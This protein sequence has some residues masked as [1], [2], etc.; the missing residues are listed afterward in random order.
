MKKKT[1]LKNVI[2]LLG[3]ILISAGNVFIQEFSNLDEVWIYNFARCIVDGL[4]PY[5]DFSIIMTPLFPM[6][7]AVFLK[8]I[9]NEMIVLRILEVIETTAILFMVYKVLE[10]L[11]INKW[12]A[13]LVTIRSPLYI[14][15]C[16]LL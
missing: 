12:I 6:I 11:K 8:I 3:I 5:R 7:S 13:L 10:R 9:A 14:C 1:F 15:R 4:V 2:I 16:V